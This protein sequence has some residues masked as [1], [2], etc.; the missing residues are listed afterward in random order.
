MTALEAA[1]KHT[2]ELL[3]SKPEAI[4]VFTM[5]GDRGTEAAVC[6]ENPAHALLLARALTSTAAVL[7]EQALHMPTSATIE[8]IDHGYKH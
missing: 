7:I 2:T 3:E 4:A 5:S 8:H 6:A 1:M